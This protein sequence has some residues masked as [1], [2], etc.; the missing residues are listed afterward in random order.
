MAKQSELAKEFERG[1]KH[2]LGCINFDESNLD[3]EAIQFMNEVPGRV[4]SALNVAAQID[5]LQQNGG[6]VD[7]AF[8]LL[9]QEIQT[10][11]NKFRKPDELLKEAAELKLQVNK[12]GQIMAMLL[13][14]CTQA[15][16]ALLRSS[17]ST[18]YRAMDETIV[19][20]GGK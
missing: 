3:G 15:R 9:H 7:L 10:H 16:R 18:A 6:L 5:G 19:L 11:P 2:F 14:G 12:H 1:L 17:H 20:L 8:K 4:V 13:K